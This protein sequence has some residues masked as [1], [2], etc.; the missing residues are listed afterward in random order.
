MKR[1]L[2]TAM[3]SSMLL[4]PMGT[5]AQADHEETSV[6]PPVSTEEF[7]PGG[8][9]AQTNA[10]QAMAPAL[11]GMVMA[12]MN[13]GVSSFDRDDATLGWESLY[14]MLSLYG[15]LDNRSEYQNSDS[16]ILLSETVQDYSAAMGLSLSDLGPLPAELSDRI[17]YDPAIDSYQVVCGNNDQ[18]QFQI[19]TTRDQGSTLYVTGALVY[20]V[21]GSDLAQFQATLQLQDNMFGY[22]ITSLNILK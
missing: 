7:I 18:A 15:Q 17:T 10:A 1:L 3:I 8:V 12:M 21:N 22:T 2:I 5:V 6:V 11:H 16:L 20:L 13:H 19:R 4:L 14:N 9:P